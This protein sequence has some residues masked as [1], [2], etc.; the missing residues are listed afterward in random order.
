MTIALKGDYGKPCPA[1]VIQADP[2]AGT[3]TVLLVTSTRGAGDT[4]QS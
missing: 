4:I 3:V 1:L 2:F